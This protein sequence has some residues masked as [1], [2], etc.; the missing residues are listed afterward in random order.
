MHLSRDFPVSVMLMDI[1]FAPLEK[2][3][4]VRVNVVGL[5]VGTEL[6]LSM[7]SL[8]PLCPQKSQFFS[9]IA[10]D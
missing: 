2:T 3:R 7:P 8:L 10:G 9:K 5:L 1:M 6:E 4:A